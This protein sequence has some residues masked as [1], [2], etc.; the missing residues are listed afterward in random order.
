MV[1]SWDWKTNIT[2][3]DEEKTTAN[4][5][6]GTYPPSLIRGT[7]FH[8]PADVEEVFAFGGTT[9]MGNT[10]FLGYVAPDTSTYPLWSYSYDSSVQNPNKWNQYDIGQPWKPN[11]GAA[12]E[13]VD[14]S[15][16][17]YLN[18]QIDKGTS[19]ATQN[20]GNDTTVHLGGMLVID[21]T[22]Q[23]SKNISTANIT[24][25][26]P[27]VGGCM[28]YIAPV[29]KNG[30]LVALGGQLSPKLNLT[31]NSTDG[32]LL[33]FDVV[34]IFD[35]NSYLENTGGNGTWYSQSTSGDIPQPRIDFCTVSASAP[36]NS[37]HHIYLYGGRDP[38]KSVEYDDV[39]VLSLPAFNWTQVNFGQSP[40]WGHDCHVVGNRQMLTIGGNTTNEQ[41]DWEIK[42][43]AILDMS[44][45]TWGSVY[46]AYAPEYL[47]PTPIVD[48]LGGSPSGGATIKSPVLGYNQTGLAEVFNTTRAQPSLSATPSQTPVG[49]PGHKSHAGA[50][51]GGVIGGVAALAMLAGLLLWLRARKRRKDMEP[52][53]L[54]GA[55][56]RE[57]QNADLQSPPKHHHELPATLEKPVELA[58]QHGA[59]EAPRETFT[60][61]AE[62]SGTNIVPGGMHGVPMIR[63]PST[64]ESH[65]PFAKDPA[66]R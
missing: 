66:L 6:T 42:G 45:I 5:K 56:K 15:L 13:A 61:A 63:T 30:I 38:I 53:E 19:A 29:G 65:Y 21:L 11:H 18:G 47:V 12:A 62:L 25:Y 26:G 8:G 32:S 49:A 10:S 37:S 51:A 28:E 36:D 52:R 20:F 57:L 31:S 3:T 54:D 23:T 16:G 59:S 22:S 43:V 35:I 1:T 4:P 50:I 14:Q 33:G 40:R 24:G 2:I 48:W 27:R 39:Y 60:E 64:E 17:F 58:E 34:D 41:C 44:T 46:N 9:F 55:E 7:M